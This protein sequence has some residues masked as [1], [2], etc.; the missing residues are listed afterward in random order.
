MIGMALT[1]AARATPRGNPVLIE[2]ASD[3]RGLRGRPLRRE[4][5]HEASSPTGSEISGKAVRAKTIA[6]FPDVCF[7]PPQNPATPPGVPVPYP[8]F[9]MAGETEKGTGTV[10]IGG[11]TIN[12]KNKSDMTKTTGNEA[13]CA[14]EE[15][16]QPRRTPART[17]SDVVPNVKRTGAGQPDDRHHH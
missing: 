6:A 4:G 8:N 9:A 3:D 2:T 14:A 1:A 17:T 13:G 16:A 11:K 5:R 15:R 12:L 7:T 10:K